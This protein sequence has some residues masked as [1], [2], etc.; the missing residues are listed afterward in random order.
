MTDH[1]HIV[2]ISVLAAELLDEARKHD[3]RRTAKTIVS[4]TLLR[5]TLIALVEGVELA[6]HDAP[7]AA[8]LYIITGLVRL[9]TDTHEWLL[10]SGDLAP[11]P[12]QRH[13]LQALT[14][15]TVLLTV[16]LH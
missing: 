15:A 3:S 7:P 13:G 6:E 12:Y 16:A 4:G 1:A 9:H 11:I 14:D 8:T 5:A 10:N 2:Q